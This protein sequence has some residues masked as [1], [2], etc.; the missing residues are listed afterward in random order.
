MNFLFF[1]VEFNFFIQFLWVNFCC[2]F[3]LNFFLE[4][5]GEYFVVFLNKNFLQMNFKDLVFLVFF[6]LKKCEFYRNIKK[7]IIYK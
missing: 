3:P 5:M 1:F 6:I 4:F 7:K 2:L